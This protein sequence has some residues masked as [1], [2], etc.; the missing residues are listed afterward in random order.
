VIYSAIGEDTQWDILNFLFTQ[1]HESRVETQKEPEI[2]FTTG[3]DLLTSGSHTKIITK[4]L[5]TL[6]TNSDPRYNST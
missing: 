6:R 3:I 2:Y 1:G 4:M 5:S